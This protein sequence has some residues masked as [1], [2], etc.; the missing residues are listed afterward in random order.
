MKPHHGVRKTIIGWKRQW[1]LLNVTLG[2]LANT[3]ATSFM[4][5]KATSDNH[6][7]RWTSD[8]W[9]SVPSNL[10]SSNIFNNS[11]TVRM[12]LFLFLGSF[13]IL[14]K[15][16][17]LKIDPKSTLKTFLNLE[18]FGIIWN[19]GFGSNN[20]LLDPGLQFTTTRK[21]YWRSR[22]VLN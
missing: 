20:R 11:Q 9:G 17:N 14:N 4:I 3:A 19:W 1:Q 7:N 5:I 2:I 18:Q 10:C 6:V 21:L 15:L 22:I 12:N 8:F 13:Q 16:V